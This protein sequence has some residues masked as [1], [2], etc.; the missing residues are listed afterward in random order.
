MIQKNCVSFDQNKSGAV[1]FNLGELFL[2]FTMKDK[3]M[4]LICSIDKV[5]IAIDSFNCK[6]SFMDGLL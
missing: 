3:S 4:R 2:F 6:A 1:F 5:K